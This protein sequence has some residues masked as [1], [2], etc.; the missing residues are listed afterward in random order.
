MLFQYDTHNNLVSVHLTSERGTL[1]ITGDC[2]LAQ[3]LIRFATR[4]LSSLLQKTT[5]ECEEQLTLFAAGSC[6]A[7]SHYEHQR[8]HRHI[9][10]DGYESTD[11][12]TARVEL[13]AGSTVE[14]ISSVY[15]Y[16]PPADERWT[17][18]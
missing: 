16:R 2:E 5:L 10:R 8:A 1:H 11:D 18:Q 3:R 15:T 7:H 17:R 14:I 12:K 6:A 9:A 4:A 13:S